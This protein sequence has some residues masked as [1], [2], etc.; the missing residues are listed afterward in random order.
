MLLPHINVNSVHY[1]Y[2]TA[3][4]LAVMAEVSQPRGKS[5]QIFIQCQFS[6]SDVVLM[7]VSVIL[8]ITV[9]VRDRHMSFMRVVMKTMNSAKVIGLFV[10]AYDCLLLL[11]IVCYCLQLFVIAYVQLS[12]I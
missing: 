3:A 9:L 6:L 12:I 10:I 8:S 1:I 7:V 5:F 11:T 2:L 4:A